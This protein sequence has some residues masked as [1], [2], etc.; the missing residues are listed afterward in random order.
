M[1]A[2]CDVI[3]LT[4]VAMETNLTPTWFHLIESTN[5]ACYMY[6]VSCQSDELCRRRKGGSD[7]PPSP[8]RLCVT[9][10]SSRLLGLIT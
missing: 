10:F 1:A 7:C 6:Q 8:S 5:E 3:Y 2:A 4:I 9:I